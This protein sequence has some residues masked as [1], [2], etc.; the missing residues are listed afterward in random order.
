[1]FRKP[2]HFLL[3]QKFLKFCKQSTVL[4]QE[5]SHAQTVGHHPRIRP[6]ITEDT[7]KVKRELEAQAALTE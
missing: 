3:L 5:K 7:E 6:A 1:M 4:R 2:Q